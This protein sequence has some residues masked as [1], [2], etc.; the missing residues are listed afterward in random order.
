[1]SQKPRPQNSNNSNNSSNPIKTPELSPEF[2]QE[3]I[4]NQSQ[5]ARNEAAN[6]AL[7]EKELESNARLAEKAMDYQAALLK[8]K[9]SETRKTATRLAWILGFMT[10]I[11]MVFFILLL[12]FGYER[13]A[14]YFIKGLS[15]VGVSI[16]SYFFGKKAKSKTD[17]NGS[18]TDFIEDADVV[19]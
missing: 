2:L 9:P 16:G 12:Q 3:W 8:S 10:I 13:F 7:R 15:Y 11:F 1:M 18:G 4:Y 6:I 5:Q 17:N 19:K 14:E